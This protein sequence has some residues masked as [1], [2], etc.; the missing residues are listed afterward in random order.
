M[1][2]YVKIKIYNTTIVSLALYGCGTWYLTLRET[3][4]LKRFWNKVTIK[5]GRKKEN[6]GQEDGENSI[7]RNFIIYTLI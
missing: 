6:R 7:M 2:R 5:S 3:Q 1:F 4:K